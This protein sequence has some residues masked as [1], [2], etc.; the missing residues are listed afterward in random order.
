MTAKL[1]K[2]H[3]NVTKLCH[4]FAARSGWRLARDAERASHDFVRAAEAVDRR[5]RKLLAAADSSPSE[6]QPPEVAPVEDGVFDRTRLMKFTTFLTDLDTWFAAQ[7]APP[8]SAEGVA[9]LAE[10]EAM[11]AANLQ[12]VADLTPAAEA[13]S[14][15]DTPP[16]AATDFAIEEGG[17]SGPAMPTPPMTHTDSGLHQLVL[18]DT[19]ERPMVQTFRG[20]T[21]LT[22]E[23]K[24]AVD[25]FLSTWNIQYDDIKRKTLR[26][27]LV[28]W[29]TSAPHGQVLVIKVRTLTEPFE[30]YPSYVSRELLERTGSTENEA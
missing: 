23:C 26:E 1:A 12:L 18:D 17:S 9:L 24:E 4:F 11:L 3:A 25:E 28:R 29:I 27:R 22:P 2:A 30:P 8:T 6:P 10:M 13:P 14:S 15:S 19:D 21:E 16:L 7:P 5:L 20:I